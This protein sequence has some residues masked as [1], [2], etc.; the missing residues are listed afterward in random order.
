[1]PDPDGQATAPATVGERVGAGG[2]PRRPGAPL[3]TSSGARVEGE[4]L[5]RP[6]DD[7][8]GAWQQYGEHMGMPAE[9][10]AATIARLA[11]QQSGMTAPADHV[12]LLHEAGFGRVASYF[13]VLGGG[14]VA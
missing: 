8:L 11:E 2:A 13:S 9:Q 14:L 1:V 10:M 6:R 4:A 12:R 7:F 5:L 3:A